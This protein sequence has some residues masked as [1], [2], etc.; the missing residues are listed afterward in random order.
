MTLKLTCINVDIGKIFVHI[1]GLIQY[2]SQYLI[3]SLFNHLLIAPTKEELPS[4]SFISHDLANTDH[5]AWSTHFT[6][7]VHIAIWINCYAHSQFNSKQLQ[8]VTQNARHIV[9][10]NWKE[11]H[12]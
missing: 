5:I 8:H 7:N 1:E 4:I 10:N 6:Y 9:N 2:D 12:F 11:Q 3:T